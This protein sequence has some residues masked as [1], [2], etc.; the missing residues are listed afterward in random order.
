MGRLVGDISGWSP[1]C[2]PA[3]HNLFYSAIHAKDLYVEE[4]RDDGTVLVYPKDAYQEKVAASFWGFRQLVCA[5]MKQR[6]EII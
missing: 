6:L 5:Q 3:N 1:R 2:S 4:K